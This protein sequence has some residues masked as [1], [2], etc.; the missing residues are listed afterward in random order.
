MRMKMK[1]RKGIVKHFLKRECS[2]WQKQ[3]A[4]AEE[5]RHVIGADTGTKSCI[6]PLVS[7][8]ARV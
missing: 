2:W 6:E 7:W 1:K 8:K 4:K 5:L 3:W